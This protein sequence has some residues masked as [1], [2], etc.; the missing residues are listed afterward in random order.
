VGSCSCGRGF[1]LL[2]PIDGRAAECLT[3]S[4]NTVIRPG[5]L[6]YYLFVYNRHSDDVRHY[7]IIQEGTRRVTLLVVPGDGWNEVTA[8]R[9][10]DDMSRLLGPGVDAGVR[11]VA[12]IPPEPSSKRPIIKTIGEPH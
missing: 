6:A 9:L 12:E 11:A 3:T 1:P 2:G 10:R 7:Q 5:S 4:A 8:A